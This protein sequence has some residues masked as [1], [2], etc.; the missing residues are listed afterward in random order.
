MDAVNQVIQRRE[1]LDRG[2]SRGLLLS[3]WG[4]LLIVGVAVAAPLLL[5]KQ[6][7]LRV[8]HGQIIPLPPGGGGSPKVEEPARAAEPEPPASQPQPPVSEPQ[9]PPKVKKPPK[10]TAAPSKGVAPLDSKKKPRRRRAQPTAGSGAASQSPGLEFLPAGPG[11]PGGTDLYGD[12]YLASVQRKIWMLWNQQIRGGPQ[13]AVR[14][15]FTILADGAV[16]D[17]Q[18]ISPSG[19]YLLD[20]AA[21]RAIYSAAPFGPL[22][23]HYGTRRYTILA[24]FTPT[25]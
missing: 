1:T 22:P 25:A 7:I 15:R 18:V 13:L 16:E 9:P 21:Q 23:K 4:H 20:Q 10:K 2:F 12:W 19:V 14:V 11:A 5:P 24:N 6:P 3:V 17:V 8:V